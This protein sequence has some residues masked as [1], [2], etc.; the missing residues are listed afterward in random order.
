M[1]L[2]SDT[3]D[4]P[5]VWSGS[6]VG[7]ERSRC[8]KSD[9]RRPDDCGGLVAGVLPV[10]LAAVSD[11]LIAGVRP[12]DLA[13]LAGC[14]IA[15]VRPTDLA[16]AAECVQLDEEEGID[17]APPRPSR[18]LSGLLFVIVLAVSLQWSAIFVT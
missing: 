11:S 5:S 17:F 7:V 12:T 9:L 4:L 13:E 18:W 10:D 14:L 3:C 1:A 2:S 16:E 6:R 8:F 15:G